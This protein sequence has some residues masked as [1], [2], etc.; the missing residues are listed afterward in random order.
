[1]GQAFLGSMGQHSYCLYGWVKTK[2]Y[3]LGGVKLGLGSTTPDLFG[4]ALVSLNSGLLKK[5][6]NNN[7]IWCSKKT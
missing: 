3:V 5:K 4:L 7:L 2:D 6:N 1:M